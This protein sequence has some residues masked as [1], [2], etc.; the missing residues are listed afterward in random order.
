MECPN[1]NNSFVKISNFN[2]N[3]FNNGE[4]QRKSAFSKYERPIENC[5]TSD[6]SLSNCLLSE[7]RSPSHKINFMTCENNMANWMACINAQLATTNMLLQ[8]ISNNSCYQYASSYYPMAWDSINNT[9]GQPNFEWFPEI[10]QISRK[11]ISDHNEGN[12]EEAK[13]D[14]TVSQWSDKEPTPPVQS[15]PKPRGIY[16]QKERQEK[17]KKYKEKIQRWVR[18]ENKN[19]DRYILR[20]KIAKQKPR[21]GGKFAKKTELAGF[22]TTNKNRK[23]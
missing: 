10:P 17:I 18:G 22:K 8:L 16:T 6:D 20:S 3:P 5:K 15:E 2:S 4:S 12:W 14:T 21:V 13:Y 19:K 1:I 11:Q 7:S 23:F 9:E